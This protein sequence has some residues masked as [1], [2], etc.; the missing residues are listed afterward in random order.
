[1]KNSLLKKIAQI[2]AILSFSVPVLAQNPI[3]QNK[4]TADP[5]AV[6]VDNT[7]YLYTGHDEASTTAKDY[8][9][10]NWHVFSS[11]D[12][13]TWTDHGQRLSLST[14]SWANA[15]AFAS[16]VV[17]RNGKYYWYTCVL[18]KPQ[19]GF[20]PYFGIGVAVADNPL[21]PF[22]DALGKPLIR[23]N[24]TSDLHFDIDPCVFIDSDGQ[25]YMYWGN[26]TNGGPCK[27]VKLKANMTEIDGPITTVNIPAFTE[28]PYLHK[29][30]NMYYLSYASGWPETIAYA[31][32]NS[33]MGPWTAR[34][35]LNG[36]VS[37]ET[38]HQSIIEFGGQWYF[39]YHNAGLPTGG[40]FRRSVCIDYLYYN[41]DG[42]IKKIVQTTTGVKQVVVTDLEESPEEEKGTSFFENIGPATLVQ[43]EIYDLL[44][45]SIAKGEGTKQII[46]SYLQ[47]GVGY[48]IRIKN[49]DRTHAFKIMK[50]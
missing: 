40:N 37:S 44:G 39:V 23:D 16:H 10:N 8:V 48:V 5:C 9:M 6:V 3:I 47:E 46:V 21:G 43:Y 22:K 27:I 26:A 33:P 20:G 50:H 35:T 29:R 28:A 41:T 14:F 24:Q 11:K 30:N 18:Q 1:M 19:L 17:P 12:M 49:G 25:A 15:A 4:F 38:N 42:T 36:R 2:F 34:G 13:V 31:T 32:S 45:K 7:V